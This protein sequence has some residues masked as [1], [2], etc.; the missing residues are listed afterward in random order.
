MN[1]RLGESFETAIWM[2]GT[3]TEDMRNACV[4]DMRTAFYRMATENGVTISPPIFHVKQPG[5]ERVPP[6]PYDVSGPCVCL[7]VAE[8]MIVGYAPAN[9]P[10]GSFVQDLDAIDRERLRGITR[11]AHQRVN[12]NA[13][14]LTDAQCDAYAEQVGPES[15]A[16]A[17]RQ[18]VDSQAVH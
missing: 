15:A 3:E 13:A 14:R 6:V 4:A 18:A 1:V 7:L 16:T 12:P 5:D 10:A 8:A 9:S 2:T 17:I 11:R